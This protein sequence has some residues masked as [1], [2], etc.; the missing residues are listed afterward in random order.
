M[1]YLI[2][3]LKIIPSMIVEILAKIC[4]PI[5]ALFC[6]E[7]GWLPDWLA[8]FR[9]P[10]NSCDGDE[11]H[12]K[13]WPKDGWFWTYARRTAWLFRN[14]AYGWNLMMGFKHKEGD[15]KTVK[16]TPE[17]GDRSGVSGV[18]HYN[19]Y[20][21]GDRVAFQHYLVKHYRIFGTWRCVRMG[22]GYKVWGE[23][24]SKMYGQLWLY[25]NPIKGSAL[26][27]KENS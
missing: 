25:F 10:D 14:S 15:M 4:S 2:W 26:N 27:D 11:A 3:L 22:F 19:V 20:R 17:A 21:D 8:W 16:G 5:L 1:A 18:C 13:R 7:N 9:T 6:D 23:P 12:R 24:T